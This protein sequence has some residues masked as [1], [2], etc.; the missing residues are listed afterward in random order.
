[1]PACSHDPMNDTGF[2]WRSRGLRAAP[3][4]SRRDSTHTTATPP[5]AYLWLAV[6]PHGPATRRSAPP[7]RR[8][9]WTG[10]TSHSS[11]LTSSS[12]VCGAAA[13]SR[14]LLPRSHLARKQG[15]RQTQDNCGDGA[16]APEFQDSGWHWFMHEPNSAVEGTNEQH[17]DRNDSNCRGGPSWRGRSANR[18][19]NPSDEKG[20]RNETRS[21]HPK[22]GLLIDHRPTVPILF[23]GHGGDGN[24]ENDDHR[25][26]D[27]RPG[28]ASLVGDMCLGR[29][30]HYISLS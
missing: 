25:Y 24:D 30:D 5:P 15:S 23:D 6:P 4:R 11:R 13:K 17:S 19:D 1:M 26:G 7:S 28:S 9:W 29:I 10:H 20:D 8:S 22:V 21:N 27:V 18:C 3:T 2:A 16:Q 12:V 14:G